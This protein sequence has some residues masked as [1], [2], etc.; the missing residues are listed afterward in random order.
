MNSCTKKKKRGHRFF[1]CGR[2]GFCV[3]DFIQKSEKSLKKDMKI[4][5]KNEG[6]KNIRKAKVD[7]IRKK[8]KTRG[9]KE[10]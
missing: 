4:G 5:S 2:V 1:S 8:T 3:S 9:I 6:N 10:K 7:H